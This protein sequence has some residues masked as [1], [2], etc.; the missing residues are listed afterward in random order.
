[1]ALNA[2]QQ[3]Y[4]EWLYKK[5]PFLFAVA[6]KRATGKN[7]TAS[8]LGGL[9]GIAD[10]FGALKNINFGNLAT[11]IATTATQLATSKAQ[12]DIVKAQTQ[13]AVNG[14]PPIDVQYY[15]TATNFNPLTAN[16]QMAV[17]TTAAQLGSN[18][19]FNVMSMLPWIVLGIGGALIISRLRRPA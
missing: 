4:L 14:Q 17:N 6:V 11:S 18:S 2:N 10:I 5:D 9:A 8:G 15:P 19:G 1:M 16:G 7:I 13:R 3:K 12:I